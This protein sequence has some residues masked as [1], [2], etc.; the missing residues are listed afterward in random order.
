MNA[1]QIMPSPFKTYNDNDMLLI[2]AS[3][4]LHQLGITG[5]IA[6]RVRSNVVLSDYFVKWIASPVFNVYINISIIDLWI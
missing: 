6:N 4:K 1:Q 3:E 5:D 2:A